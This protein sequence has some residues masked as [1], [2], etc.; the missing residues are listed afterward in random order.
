MS[1]GKG[2][3]GYDFK[4]VSYTTLALILG[5]VGGYLAG[6]RRASE[7]AAGRIADALSKPLNVQVSVTNS[8]APP[9]G[10]KLLGLFADVAASVI[11]KAVRSGTETA[12]LPAVAAE[13]F[14]KGLSGGTGTEIGKKL[15]DGFT[16]LISSGFKPTSDKDKERQEVILFFTQNT[17]RVVDPGRIVVPSPSRM[18]ARIVFDIGKARLTPLADATIDSVRNFAR[19]NPNAILLLSANADTLGSEPRNIDLAGQ[20]SRAVRK[21]L[22]SAGGIAANRVF[23]ADLGNVSLPIVTPTNTAEQQNRSVSIEVRD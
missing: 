19:D 17:I 5:V 2:D 22:L 11:D 16:D 15:V 6:S 18:E 13:E 14:A 8:T 4:L 1:D 7:V 21:R 23:V 20:R 3:L 10:A 9:Q 12:R